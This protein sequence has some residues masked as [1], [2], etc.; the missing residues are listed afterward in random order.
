MLI[1][2]DKRTKS[3]AVKLTYAEDDEETFF[4]PENLYLIGTMNTA[5][6]S[7]AIVDYALRRRFAFIKLEPILDKSFTGFLED[8]GVSGSLAAFI[9]SAVQKV[10]EK[11][12]A[13]TNLGD[14]FQI[15]H[16]YFCS[17]DNKKDEKEWYDEILNFELRPLLEEIWFDN[18]DN[19]D[20]MMKILKQ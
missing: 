15:G 12:V 1:E 3:Y 7:L 10:N 13:D 18:L 11:I 8:R 9:S 5:D 20:T 16:S 2:H 14:G 4:V 6:R 17:Y 19:V